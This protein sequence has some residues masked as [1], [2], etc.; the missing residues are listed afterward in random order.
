MTELV[1]L[2]PEECER[3]LRA[4]VF[5][6]LVLT[7]V[8]GRV[9]VVPVNYVT[10]GDAIWVRTTPGSLLDRYADRA[11]LLLE[12][13]HVDYGRRHGWSVVARGRGQRLGESE[14]SAGERHAPGPPRWV[15]RDDAVWVRLR[16]QEL[17]GRRTGA[18]W[19]L[20]AG[21]PVSRAAPTPDRR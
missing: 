7:T 21:L 6:R 10:A 11:P 18:G 17:S 13:D 4:G 16:W 8:A 20:F 5:G 9:E 1:D 2:T 3:L 12:I 14:R 15:R 19:D